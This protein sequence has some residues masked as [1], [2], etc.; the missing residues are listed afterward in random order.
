MHGLAIKLWSSEFDQDSD[1]FRTLDSVVYLTHDIGHNDIVY[2]SSVIS[3]L[4]GDNSLEEVFRKHVPVVKGEPISWD[5]PSFVKEEHPD[6]DSGNNDDHKENYFGRDMEEDCKDAEGKPQPKK[7]KSSLDDSVSNNEDVNDE[8]F[9][10]KPKK[11]RKPR[12]GPPLHSF[13][14][15]GRCNACSRECA[16]QGALVAHLKICNP[17]QLKEMP[18]KTRKRKP[19]GAKRAYPEYSCTYCARKFSFKKALEKHELLHISD[20]DSKKLKESTSRKDP[21]TPSMP[22]GQYQCDK[23]QA[24]FTMHSALL[25][26]A[27]AHNLSES[28]GSKPGEEIRDGAIMKCTICDVAYTTSGMY[29]AHMKKYHNKS[30][31]CDDCGKRFTLPNALKNHIINHHTTFPKRCDDC[32]HYCASKEE[33]KE[34]M[35]NAHGDGVQEKTNPCEICGNMFKSKYSLKAHVKLMHSEAEEFPCDQCGKVFRAKASLEYHTK[36]H[37]GDY[38]YRCDECGN[39]FMRHD[40]ML[41]CKNAHAG[42]FKFHC[43]HCDYKTNKE[44]QYKRHIT[45]HSNDKPF[46]CPICGHSSSTVGNLSS[47]VRKVHKIT[48]VKSE[49]LARRNRHGHSMNEDELAEAKR[50]LELTEKQQDTMKMKPEGAANVA[51]N[52]NQ[53][54]AKNSAIIK[55]QSEEVAVSGLIPPARLLFPYL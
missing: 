45:V 54:P 50:K 41:D 39:G 5:E 17:E 46:T 8:D 11:T 16:N 52:F 33:F 38:P 37:N 30:L 29:Q 10:S 13:S 24:V 26:H 42:I 55:T 27:E 22:N 35:A 21:N 6:Y 40:H 7:R 2:I 28:V 47:H 4:V 14:R 12:S 25:R 23:C 31:G 32:S 1:E 20:P 53:T 48:L 34:H 3:H 9:G 15:P 36:V 51:N 49:I 19:E 44:R 18:E 43:P